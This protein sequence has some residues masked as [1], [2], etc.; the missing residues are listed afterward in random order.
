MKREAALL[1]CAPVNVRLHSWAGLKEGR[2]VQA[3]ASILGDAGAMLPWEDAQQL[4][5]MAAQLVDVQAPLLQ[6]LHRKP[7]QRAS[8]VSFCSLLPSA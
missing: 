8:M 2:G 6:L 4:A 3:I 7:S 1:P 5:G